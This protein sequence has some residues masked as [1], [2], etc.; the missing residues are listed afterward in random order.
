MRRIADNTEG[1]FDQRELEPEPETGAEEGD[2]EATGVGVDGR[3]IL[4]PRPVGESRR[5]GESMLGEMATS[6]LDVKR[7]ETAKSGHR[8]DAA[9]ARLQ[10]LAQLEGDQNSDNDEEE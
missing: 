9:E 6:T 10:R 8:R 7:S 3:P 5:V 4:Q 1:N 2:M